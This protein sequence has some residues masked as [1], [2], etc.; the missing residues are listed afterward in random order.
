MKNLIFASAFIFLSVLAFGHGLIQEPPSRN[1][2]CGA[3]TKPDQ[4]AQGSAEFPICSTAFAQDPIAPYNYMAVLTHTLGRADVSPLPQNVCSFD[5]ESW[6]GQTTP[7]D[8]PMEWPTNPMQAGPQDFT[9]NITWGP[10]FDDTY[11]FSYWITKAD[12]QFSP[13]K[14]LTWEDFEEEPFCLQIYNDS[15]PEA[16]A[17]IQVDKANNLFT[18]SCELPERSGHHV[19]YAEWGRT[20]PTFERFHGCVDG[21]FGNVAKLKPNTNHRF[22]TFQKDNIS[23]IDLLGRFRSPNSSFQI[24]FSPK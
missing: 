19:I 21:A 10:H 23:S 7:W 9:W 12:F 5:S 13:E 1:W 2:I 22:M 20:G 24:R 6:D 11:D 17:D 16:N 3:T 18:T 14:A 15:N 8:V 4:V